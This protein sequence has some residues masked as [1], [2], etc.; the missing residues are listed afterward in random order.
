MIATEGKNIYIEDSK[1]ENNNEISQSF[2]DPISIEIKPE[3]I[4]ISPDG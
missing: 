2:N 4:E 1:I 3:K